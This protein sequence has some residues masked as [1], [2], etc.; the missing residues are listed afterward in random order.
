MPHGNDMER[1]WDFVIE[2]FNNGEY[3]IPSAEFCEVVRAHFHDEDTI[4]REWFP[5]YLDGIELLRQFTRSPHD[6]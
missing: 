3:D 2:A 1:F 6:V 4:R 5:K